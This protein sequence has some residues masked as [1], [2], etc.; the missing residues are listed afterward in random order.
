MPTLSLCMIARDEERFLAGCLES[1]RG[2][3]D[4]VV[5]VDTGSRDATLDIARTM[6]ARVL[7]RAWDDDFSA[8]RNFSVEAARGTHVLVLDADERLAPGGASAL[9]AALADDRLLLG[10]LPLHNADALDA[11]VQS[12]L[13]G[14]RRIGGPVW[15]PR[16][17]PRL[18]ELRFKRRVHETLMGGVAVLRAE[19]RGD[20]RVIDAPLVHLGEQPD[21]RAVLGREARNERLLRRAL[22]EDVADGDLAGYLV[23]MLLRAERREEARAVG[24]R[25]LEPFLRAVD[26]RPAGHPAPS[27][28]RLGYA[29]SFAQ[30][31]TNAA[32]AALYTAR[33]CAARFPVE[34]PNLVFA[35][36]Y[37]LEKLGRF[38]EAAA[39]Y[40][41]CLTL[42]GVDSSQ[43]VLSGVTGDLARLRLAV[44][45]A[46]RGALEEAARLLPHVG[47]PW[48]PEARR[49]AAAIAQRGA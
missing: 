8:A 3:V 29:L 12:V 14:A 42:H 13:S 27:T 30:A 37:A 21:L 17:F 19:G 28:V 20:S 40:G 45:H 22:E 44:V 18:P 31:D 33:E 36:A 25:S 4:E 47:G 39:R 7:S 35:E 1:V 10:M 9:R 2:V 16:L 49:L 43:Q 15:V 34:H 11:P 46:A 48:A 23:G 24:E 6:G 26:V 38:D 32:E 5:L 41:R